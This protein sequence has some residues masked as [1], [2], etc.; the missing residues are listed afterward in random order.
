MLPRALQVLKV[1]KK[2]PMSY[3]QNGHMT[4]N[5]HYFYVVCFVE[6]GIFLFREALFVSF[7]LSYYDC[8]NIYC[9]YVIVENIIVENFIVE[10]V[11]VENVIVENFIVENVIVENVIVEN[12]IVEKLRMLLYCC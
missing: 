12:V 9:M 7:C 3:L 10:N 8:H 4:S 5:Q 2:I 6:F 11:V 1:A